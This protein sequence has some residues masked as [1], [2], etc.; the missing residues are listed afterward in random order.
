[1]LLKLNPDPNY[2]KARKVVFHSWRHYYTSR[3]AEIFDEP[4]LM[5][6][7]G[8]KTKDAFDE[9]VNHTTPE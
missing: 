5:K 9:Y 2:W 8:H 4:T 3:M 7:T 6:A 1:M